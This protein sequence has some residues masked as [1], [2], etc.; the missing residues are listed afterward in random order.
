M[1]N[2]QQTARIGLFFVLGVALVWATFE[3]L[4]G[5]HLFGDHGY[6]VVAAFDDLKELKV[7]DEVRMAGVKIGSVEKTE[8]KGRKADAILRIDTGVKIARDATAAINMSGL[9]GNNFIAIALGS[10]SAPLL[11]DGGSIQTVSTPDL[12]TIMSQLGELGH[13]LDG[14]LS[15][16]SVALNG[17]GK[18]PGLFQNLNRLVS[19]N[20]AKV[21][22]TLTNLQAITDKLNRGQGTLGK[23][24][25]D[26]DL[27]DQ[28]LAAVSEI[29]ATAGQAQEFIANAQSIL[30]QVKSGKGALGALVYDPKT[31]DNVKVAIQNLRDVSDKLAKGEGTLGKLINDDSL[32]TSAKGT[33]TKADRALDGMNDSGPISAVGVVANSLF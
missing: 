8:L 19:D 26:P 23:L 20:S 25:N 11:A 14:A 5:G 9:I 27:H 32:Y 15:S 31:A 18:Q 16:L 4:S 13:K 6:T 21:G 17:N 30:K 10:A 12:N 22:A 29:K 24:I 2:A 28:L 33:L 7:G 3:T 1:N